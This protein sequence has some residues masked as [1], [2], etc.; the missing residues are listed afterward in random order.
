[1]NENPEIELAE[2]QL[3]ESEQQVNDEIQ[4]LQDRFLRLGAEFDNFKKRS[5]RDRQV[6]VRFASESL[7][8][9]LLPVID[10]LEQALLAAK[11]GVD[12]AIV[13]GVKMVLKQ[14]EDVLGRHGVKGFNALGEQFDP[15]KHEAMA[16]QADASVPAGQVI[17]E[18]Q[19]GYF[20][21]DRLVRPARVVVAK[22]I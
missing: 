7:L 6:S 2:E 12:D 14:F 17:Q 21:H 8:R 15:S 11:V 20:L 1:M 19:K 4:A 18:F 5:E 22:N 10:H 9:D 3:Q 16:E 13:T